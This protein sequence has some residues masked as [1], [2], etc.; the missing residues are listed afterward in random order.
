MAKQSPRQVEHRSADDF[1]SY[2]STVEMFWGDPIDVW[3]IF[4]TEIAV[5][6]ISFELTV[7]YV[8]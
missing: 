6:A 8:G 4:T 5:K 3:L 1:N 7:C 2:F